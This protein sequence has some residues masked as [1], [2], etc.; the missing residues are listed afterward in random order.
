MKKVSF[1][2]GK[3]FHGNTI[4]DK[5]QTK[6][7]VGSFGKYYKLYDEFKKH[8]YLIATDD[9]HSPEESDIVLYFDMPKQLPKKEDVYKSHLLAIES[10]IIRPENFNRIK[11]EYFHKIFT[12]NDDLVDGK[13]YI[14]INYAFNLPKKIYKE[15]HYN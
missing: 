2:A 4:F 12:W 13:K 8:G 11:H 7:K 5:N 15:I 14:K 1:V 9:I 3:V 6:L 10:S